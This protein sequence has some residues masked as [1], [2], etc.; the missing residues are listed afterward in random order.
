MVIPVMEIPP[1]AKMPVMVAACSKSFM[2]AL[3]RTRPRTATPDGP[4]APC[5]ALEVAKVREPLAPAQREGASP[6]C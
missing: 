5:P 1:V 6:L 3:Y 2:T 4:N